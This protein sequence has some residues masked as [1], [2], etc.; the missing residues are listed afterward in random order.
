MSLEKV[1]IEIGEDEFTLD[2]KDLSCSEET[3][4]VDL[5]NQ[6]SLYTWVSV[7][8]EEADAEY[9]EKK[10]SLDLMNAEL[11]AKYRDKMEKPTENKIAM[12]I[13]RDDESI[14]MKTELIQARRAVGILKAWEEG[15]RQRKEVLI[16]LASNFRAQMDTDLHINREIKRKKIRR[17]E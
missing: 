1:N 13:T 5:M 16:A 9:Q 6:P 3:I 4:D 15:F 2:P 8:R 17:E 10:M 12:A 7:L 11:D 14:K